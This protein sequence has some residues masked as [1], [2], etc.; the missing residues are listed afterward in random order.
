MPVQIKP[1]ARCPC[2]RIIDKKCLE[3][4]VGW[5]EALHPIKTLINRHFQKRLFDC[6]VVRASA[7]AKTLTKPDRRRT[8]RPSRGLVTKPLIF[9]VIGDV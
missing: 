4:E 2:Y 1:Q 7:R 6:L 9:A 5:V 8:N 3:L